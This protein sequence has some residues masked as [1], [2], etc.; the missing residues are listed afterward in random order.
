MSIRNSNNKEKF[1]GKEIDPILEFAR[2]T[3]SAA[4]KLIR[5]GLEFEFHALNKKGQEALSQDSLRKDFDLFWEKEAVNEI[6]GNPFTNPPEYKLLESL[7]DLGFSLNQLRNKKLRDK[8]APYLAA[9]K[10]NAWEEYKDSRDGDGNYRKHVNGFNRISGIAEC[11]DDNSVDGGEI[12]TEGPRTYKEFQKVCK[13]LTGKKNKWKVDGGCSFHV[14]LSLP[15]VKHKWGARF[16]AE[17]YAYL[18]GNLDSLPKPVRD[19]VFGK[20]IHWARFSIGNGGK[21]CAVFQHSQGTWEFRLFGGISK[22]SEMIKCLDVAIAT[23]QHA[24]R[25][26]AGLSPSL[27]P[28]METGKLETAL[29]RVYQVTPNIRKLKECIQVYASDLVQSR[30]IPIENDAA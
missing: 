3:D 2:A 29:D 15:G 20:G 8:M 4:R 26:R 10:A 1:I 22:Y 19:R 7:Y 16:Q 13:V 18:I 30:Q 28:G 17:M 11:G 9:Q 14:H 25:V 21:H 12:R 6:L 5:C 24:Y 27:I 23:L